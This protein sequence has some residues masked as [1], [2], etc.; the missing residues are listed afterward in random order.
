MSLDGLLAM[1]KRRRWYF[2]L[3]FALLVA[4]AVAFA[5]SLPAVYRSTGKILIEQPELPSDLVRSTV[6]S[7][8]GERIALVRQRVMTEANLVAIMDAHG[9]YPDLRGGGDESAALAQMRTDTALEM[10]TE[11]TPDPRTGRPT[12]TIVAFLVSYDS[13]S[14]EVAQAVASDLVELYLAENQKARLEA[15]QEA[16]RFLEQEANKIAGEITNLEQRLATFKT[17]SGGSLPEMMQTNIEFMQRIQERLRDVDESINAMT[18]STIL[19][20]GELAR[21]EPYLELVSPEGERVL[22][23]S[24]QLKVLEAQQLALSARY[25]AEHPDRVKVERELKALRSAMRGSGSVSPTDADNPAYIQLRSRILANEAELSALK[26][27]RA[28]LMKQ[29]EAYERR[30]AE[31]PAVEQSYLA[32]TRDYDS[33]V[34]RYNDVRGKLMEAKL[35][36][37]LETASKGE[38]FRVLEPPSLPEAPFKPN[39]PAILF[40]GAVLGIG[41]GFGSVA[42]RQSLD[43]GVY[44]AKALEGITG[45]PPLAVIP[46]IHR[47]PYRRRDRRVGSS[48]SGT[49][50]LV[51]LASLLSACYQTVLLWSSG[52]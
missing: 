29:F 25:S 7:D 34:D 12:E 39:R 6:V 42:L 11:E 41:G 27:S 22:A 31:A 1:L 51:V 18:E 30:I 45:S 37:S 8:P 28:E 14:P 21:T 44:G 20:E 36:E 5:Y 9:L 24:E 52:V 38:R 40:L 17:E 16:A 33:A 43:R 2:L 46:Y 15:T 32:L 49:G 50:L 48:P 23:P 3:P 4:S 47:R 35:A 13:R 26:T 10:V 19:L